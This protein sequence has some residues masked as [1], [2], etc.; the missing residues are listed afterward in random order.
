MSCLTSCA[1]V[2][3]GLAAFGA[4]RCGAGSQSV[5]AS[6]LSG[7]ALDACDGDSALARVRTGEPHLEQPFR[8]EKG[9]I[10][11]AG[12]PRAVSSG[13][14]RQYQVRYGT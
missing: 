7:R 3:V 5:D 11:V 8:V 2:R 10:I 13:T 9:R 14:R 6:F 1:S 4:N 12:S